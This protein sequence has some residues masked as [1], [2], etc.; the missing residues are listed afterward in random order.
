MLGTN[1]MPQPNLHPQELAEGYI[2]SYNALHGV[3][4]R[5]RHMNGPWFM[6]NGEILHQ[7]TL[8]EELARLRVLA[9]R[10]HPVE[11]NLIKRLIDRLKSI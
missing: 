7:N 1:D 2:R 11:K 5:I 8:Q 4:P 6:V 3:V 9:E 10:R